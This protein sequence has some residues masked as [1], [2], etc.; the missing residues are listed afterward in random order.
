M[1]PNRCAIVVIELPTNTSCLAASRSKVRQ[2]RSVAGLAAPEN[3]CPWQACDM[4]A[5]LKC[6]RRGSKPAG[7]A[8]I[9]R[10]DGHALLGWRLELN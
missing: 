3:F 4:L 9:E 7:V 6:R 5:R 8:L 2:H 1:I 10:A